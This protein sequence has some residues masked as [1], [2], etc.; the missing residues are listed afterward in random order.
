MVAEYELGRFNT[1]LTYIEW[2]LSPLI[3]K[4]IS[5]NSRIGIA[6]DI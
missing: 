4:T 1:L 5:Y 6:K 2:A 3:L